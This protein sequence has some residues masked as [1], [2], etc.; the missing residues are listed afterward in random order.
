MAVLVVVYEE[1]YSKFNVVPTF[2]ALLENCH[3][4]DQ[5]LVLGDW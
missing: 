2:R 1:Y 3:R 4:L 5:I